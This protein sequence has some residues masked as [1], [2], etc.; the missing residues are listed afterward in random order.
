MRRRDFITLLGGAAA[1]PFAAWAQRERVRR[2][3]V[4]MGWS[5]SDPEYAPRLAAFF[6]VLA[7][8]GWT[9]GR[10]LQTDI[11]WTNGEVDRARTFAKELV[12]LQP[13]VILAGATPVTAA[14][15]RATRTIPIVFAVV[16]DPVGAGFVAS[17]ARPGGNITGFINIEATMGGKWVELLKEMAPQI[18]RVAIMFN[19]DTAPGGGTYFRGSFDVAARSL[20]LEPIAASVRSDSGIEAAIASLGHGQG[21][22]VA[23]TDS[24][25]SVHRRTII[26]AASNNHVPT[27]FADVLVPREGAL[28]AYG[29]NNAD[30]FRRSANYVDRILRGAKAGDLPVQLPTK[31]DLSIN[32]KTAKALGLDVPASL[33][34]LADEVIE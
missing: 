27:I 17:L 7:Q 8:L 21:G 22:L 1:W 23:A 18:G 10:N 13:D 14:L 25:L 5:G 4:L 19:P 26:A 2:I 12:E 29:T 11:R 24:F 34:Q 31:F 28:I 30:M 32:L 9:E 20:G 16:S 3:G 6:Q 15:Q 33:Q